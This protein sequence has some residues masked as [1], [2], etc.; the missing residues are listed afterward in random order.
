MMAV[1]AFDE[2]LLSKGNCP[3]VVEVIAWELGRVT[4]T[5]ELGSMFLGSVGPAILC[6]VGL[7]HCLLLL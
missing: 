2:R 7:L 5:D 1:F 6:S 3:C 4:L